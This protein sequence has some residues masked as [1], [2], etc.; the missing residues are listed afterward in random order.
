MSVVDKVTEQ[1]ALIELKDDDISEYI[2]GIIEDA[3]MEEDEKREVISEF[4]SEATDKDTKN[5]IDH[6][7][8]DWRQAY[9]AQQKEAEE[10]KFKMIQEAKAREEERRVKAEKEHEENATLRTAQKQLSKE[11]KDA[12]DKLMQQYGYVADGDDEDKKEEPTDLT[13][14]DRRRGK[15]LPT[16]DPLLAA[17][18]NADIVREKEQAHREGL[19]QAS[20]KEK[21]RNRMLL[22][23]QKQE[24]EK[25]KEKKK[26][27]KGERRRM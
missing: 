14:R 12:R 19:K 7:L 8:K 27:Q 24:K 22:K 26:T 18:R 21:E 5:L 13:P 23:K 16:D 9:H 2:T 25:D 10:K 15:T 17:N 20:E 4:L 6:L 1:L 3:S 11:Q